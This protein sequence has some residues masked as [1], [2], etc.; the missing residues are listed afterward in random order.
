VR[1]SCPDWFAGSYRANS[2]QHFKRGAMMAVQISS[3]VVKDQPLPARLIPATA[4]P[5]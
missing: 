3:T 2:Y 1:L 4:V 5:Q